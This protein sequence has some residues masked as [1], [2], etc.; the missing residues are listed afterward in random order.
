MARPKGARRNAKTTVTTTTT[1]GPTKRPGRRTVVRRN[2]KGNRTSTTTTVI[3]TRP[4]NTGARGL[5]PR[6]KRPRRDA[7]NTIT[8]T[9]TATLGTVGANQGKQ[10]ETE[11]V[12][13]M[14]PA[15]TKET[16]GSNQF[17]PVQMYASTYAQWQVTRVH[18]KATPLVGA[19]AV[20]GTVARIS[21]N[22]TGGPTS[23]SWSALGAR[24]HVDVT[25]GR[26]A[27]LRLNK[28]HFPGPK[29]GW[30]N[31]NTKGDP[32]ISIGGS[33]EVHTLGKTMSTYQAN[34]FNGDLFLLEM[35]AVWKFRNYSPQPGLLNM[36]KGTDEPTTAEQ[37][38]IKA[39]NGQPIELV[40]PVT[41]RMVRAASSA[42]SEIIWQIVDTTVSQVTDLFPA[43]FN[44]LFKGGWWFIK[45]VVGAPVRAGQVTYRVYSS[46]QDA[47]ADVPCIAQETK[48]VTLTGADFTYQQ[49]T[50]GNIGLGEDQQLA[51]LSADEPNTSGEIFTAGSLYNIMAK[52]SD[53]TQKDFPTSNY[54]TNMTS[55]DT[56]DTTQIWWPKAGIGFCPEGQTLATGATSIDTWEFRGNFYQSGR[57]IDPSLLPVGIPIYAFW[58]AAGSHNKQQIGIAVAANTMGT[59]WNET[60]GG[61]VTNVLWKPTTTAQITLMPGPPTGSPPACQVLAWHW[62]RTLTCSNSTKP[63][64]HQYPITSTGVWGALQFERYV[65]N[66]A[67]TTVTVQPDK[68]YITAFSTW[69]GKPQLRLGGNF[70]INVNTGNISTKVP[71]DGTW[72]SNITA[73]SKHSGVDASGCYF[74]FAPFSEPTVLPW[75]TTT[76]EAPVETLQALRDLTLDDWDPEDDE[77]EPELLVSEDETET[78][79][80]N[81]SEP[82]CDKPDAG[83]RRYPPTPEPGPDGY[84]KPPPLVMEKL[85]KKAREHYHQLASNGVPGDVSRIAAQET[86]PHPAYVAWRSA[87]N[88]A[89][90]DGLSPST[91]RSLAWKEACDALGSRGHAE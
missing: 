14:N 83:E 86:S 18:V 32:N 19:S 33:I 47:R 4:S 63:S 85:T 12:M 39:E 62:K 43:P 45:R 67:T 38:Q 55:P 24:V 89:L 72:Q 27:I 66:W 53:Q 80:G 25:P 8:T 75:S 69:N 29:E 40:V 10:V 20:S 2:R 49:V 56:F 15:L 16:T 64:G 60:S 5:R 36:V 70:Q 42:E 90:V 91:A 28:K 44:W 22:M 57:E 31:C 6:P 3:S 81:D 26:T 37:V 34:A 71:D 54:Y 51:S 78:D 59:R 7:P 1:R 82:D 52:G 35:T 65:F 88:D 61:F 11:L 74:S 77:S 21:L 58:D 73:M 17:G 84:A 48:N 87:Y 41:S 23:S 79:T 13:L 76:R 9:V 50:P 46:I 30:Y 68:W